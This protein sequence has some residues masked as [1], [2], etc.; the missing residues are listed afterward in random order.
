VIESHLGAFLGGGYGT[1]GHKPASK[2]GHYFWGNFKVEEHLAADNLKWLR[3][4][5]NNNITFWKMSPAPPAKDDGG[6]TSIF[7]NVDAEFRAMQWREREYVLGANGRRNRLKAN[8]PA[9]R[10]TVTRYD[11]VT[12]QR[13]V[14]H[15]AVRGAVEFET[16]DSRAGLFHFKRR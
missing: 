13:R 9:G 8:L 14:L 2:Q 15:D 6:R 5:I 4:Q 11:V 3:E 1:T 7:S 12:R 10:W 16:P